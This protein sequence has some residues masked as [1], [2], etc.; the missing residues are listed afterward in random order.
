MAA[1]VRTEWNGLAGYLAAERLSGDVPTRWNTLGLFDAKTVEEFLNEP[2]LAI[3][4]RMWERGKAAK[5]DEKFEP[6]RHSFDDA[7][8]ERDLLTLVMRFGTVVAMAERERAREEEEH[9]ER[10]AKKQT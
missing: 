1:R 3:E 8:N 10:R 4:K 2:I 5:K 7:K 9:R 6:G